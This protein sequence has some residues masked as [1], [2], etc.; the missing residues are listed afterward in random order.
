MNVR[1]VERHWIESGLRRALDRQE[2]VLHYQ[3]KMN[4]E[5]GAM[6]GAEA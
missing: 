6:T 3:P 5:T 1:A 2:F 4:L